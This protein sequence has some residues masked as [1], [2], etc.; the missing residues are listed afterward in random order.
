MRV[1][2]P[3]FP[4]ERMVISKIFPNLRNIYYCAL[5]LCFSSSQKFI[6]SLV[7]F[8]SIFQIMVYVFSCSRYLDH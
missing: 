3:S 8:C 6:D 7:F 5:S 2:N 1:F 4:F